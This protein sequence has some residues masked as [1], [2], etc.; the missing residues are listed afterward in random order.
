MIK[1]FHCSFPSKFGCW[2]SN[3]MLKKMT[4][5]LYSKEE[6]GKESYI[7]NGKDRVFFIIAD[8]DKINDFI[9]FYMNSSEGNSPIMDR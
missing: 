5:M 1:Y 2:Y 7:N 8:K 4:A 9:G 6:L 3:G